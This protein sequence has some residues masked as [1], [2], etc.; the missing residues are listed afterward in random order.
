MMRTSN[1]DNN[2]QETEIKISNIPESTVLGCFEEDQKI[3]L[4]LVKKKLMDEDLLRSYSPKVIIDKLH[5]Q[6][7]KTNA[8]SAV[9]KNTLLTEVETTMDKIECIWIP[10]GTTMR[11]R[12]RGA[13]QYCRD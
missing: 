10:M 3:T 8:T 13:L 11:I 1:D 2:N 5:C 6:R 12:N 9:S 7:K 4:E